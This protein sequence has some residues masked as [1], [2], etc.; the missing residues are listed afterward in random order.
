MSYLPVIPL[1]GF[2]GWA[3]LNR[4]RDAQQQA[5]NGSAEIR[6]DTEYFSEN[7]GKVE[8]ARDLVSDRRLLK[9]A[10]GAFGLDEDINATFFI[11]KVLA[12]GTAL[13]DALANRLSDERYKSL[14]EAFGLG[15]GAF[16]RVRGSNF[17]TEIVSLFQNKQFEIAV[18]EQDP[19]MRLAL[20]LDD[21]LAKIASKDTSDAGRWYSI[22]GNPPVRTVFETAL[23][24]PAS[25]GTLDLDQQL[26]TFRDKSE[27]FFGSS[28]AAQ[29]A[30]PEKREELVELFLLKSQI[31]NGGGAVYSPASAA[32]AL[33]S[34]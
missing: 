24:L 27:A 4:T 21:G 19:D 18:G 3:F 10:L 11:E 13:S 26:K 2:G 7:I 34:S 33:L 32:L 23:S 17:A 28:E 14:T 30:N 1:S 31:A 9:V 12:D 29:F 8:S 6:R 22:M 15:Q 25:F 16:P 5:F 20:A